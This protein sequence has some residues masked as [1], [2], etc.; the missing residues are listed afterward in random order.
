VVVYKGRPGGVLWLS[1]TVA[2][3][4]AVSTSDVLS[5]HLPELRSGQQESSLT[6]AKNYVQSLVFEKLT[7]DQ[8]AAPPPTIPTTTTTR[9]K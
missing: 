7:A 9:R 8:A 4:T 5:R 3:N 2:F 6:A 1:P